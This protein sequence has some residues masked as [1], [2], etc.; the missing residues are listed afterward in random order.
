VA[1]AAVDDE[2]IALPAVFCRLG[3]VDAALLTG[4]SAC[5]DMFDCAPTGVDDPPLLEG[6][7]EEID[8]RDAF[9]FAFA[10]GVERFVERLRISFPLTTRLSLDLR[11]S[12][13]S[14]SDVSS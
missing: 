6:P 10:M 11:R 14:I 12:R 7:A 8:G 3:V 2:A 5:K 1:A 13:V 9:G 4:R